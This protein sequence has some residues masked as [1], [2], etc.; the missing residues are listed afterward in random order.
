MHFLHTLPPNENSFSDRVRPSFSKLPVRAFKSNWKQRNEVSP[1]SSAMLI[2]S[3]CGEYLS[4]WVSSA[5]QESA[6][7]VFLV[8]HYT[9]CWTDEL[10]RWKEREFIGG[11]WKKA[12]KMNTEFCLCFEWTTGFGIHLKI[13]HKN[14][15]QIKQKNI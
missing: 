6:W 2:R 4:I 13:Y 9:C 12:G 3:C 11:A 15:T 8:F 7:V 5:S 10:G 14:I 1:R